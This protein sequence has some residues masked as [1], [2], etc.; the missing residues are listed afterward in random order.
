MLCGCAST[1]VSLQVHALIQGRLR[2]LAVDGTLYSGDRFLLQVDTPI[3]AYVYALRPTQR[4]EERLYPPKHVAGTLVKPGIPLYIPGPGQF[5][6]LDQHT[7]REK[8]VVVASCERL[9]DA[10]LTKL[11]T[12]LSQRSKEAPSGQPASEDRPT[13][14][15]PPPPPTPTPIDKGGIG[16][17]LR[18]PIRRGVPAV[19]RFSFNHESI[20]QNRQGL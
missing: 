8:L 15:P 16:Q 13:K 19:L 12:P 5:F 14:K 4:G 11:S 20:E 2:G 10:A 7:G 17:V 9:E 1:Q 6:E 3:P 18:A